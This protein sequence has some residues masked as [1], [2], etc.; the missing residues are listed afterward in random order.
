M[1]SAITGDAIGNDVDG[2]GGDS[3]SNCDVPFSE[4]LSEVEKAYDRRTPK[5]EE[6]RPCAKKNKE[7]EG[8][9]ASGKRNVLSEF[10]EVQKESKSQR[11]RRKAKLK[12]CQDGVE[13]MASNVGKK[14]QPVDPQTEAAPAEMAR[15][16]TKQKLKKSVK[17]RDADT[18][19]V[20]PS[21]RLAAYGI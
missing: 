8:H 17:N 21:S 1:S 12:K 19:P 18:V 2:D 10:D 13:I 3:G 14:H 15:E 11:K 9:G 16:E 7:D 4:G 6:K 5:T 20:F